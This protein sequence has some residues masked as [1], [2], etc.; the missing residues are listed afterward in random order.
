MPWKPNLENFLFNYTPAPRRGRGVYCFTSVRPSKIFF[1]AFFSVTVDGRN[2]IFGHKLHI[3]TPYRGKRFWTH[4]IPT[5]CL[6]TLLIFIHI[7]HTVKPVYSGHL[8]ENDKMTT[9]YRWPLYGGFEFSTRYC[10]FVVNKPFL[11]TCYVCLLF[12]SCGHVTELTL[13]YIYCWW[14]YLIVILNKP[15]SSIL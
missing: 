9:I 15:V 10:T 12:C 4:Q 6:P 11:I 7:E 14:S 13:V 3:G 2:L 1:V 8:G 5:S